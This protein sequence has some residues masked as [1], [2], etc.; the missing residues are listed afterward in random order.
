MCI[1][2]FH[3]TLPI[4]I[5]YANETLRFTKPDSMTIVYAV[6]VQNASD[7][8]IEYLN[9]LVPRRL[10]AKEGDEW[11]SIACAM[12]PPKSHR[13]CK[14]VSTDTIRSGRARPDPTRPQFNLPPLEGQWIKDAAPLSVPPLSV[15]REGLSLLNHLEFSYLLAGFQK[16]PLQPWES[17]WFAGRLGRSNRDSTQL[18]TFL[19]RL[20][21]CVSLH[22]PPHV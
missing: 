20:T 16:A 10:Y 14:T 18:D 1:E 12:L 11:T 6:L 22:S 19:L 21:G 8:P 2:V 7:A 9:V 3:P 13:V 5:R 15:P 17:R 4:I